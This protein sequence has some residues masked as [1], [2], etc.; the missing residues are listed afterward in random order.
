M[1][2][3]TTIKTL[4]HTYTAIAIIDHTTCALTM[5]DE[6]TVKQKMSRF[7]SPLI[8]ERS[9]KRS[10]KSLEPEEVME[11]MEVIDIIEDGDALLVVNGISAMGE[12][13]VGLRVS[14]FALGMVSNLESKIFSTKADPHRPRRSSRH[15]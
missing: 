10:R 13:Q 1:L 8:G 6:L 11:V 9:P 14:S 3:P 5:D 7:A 2:L 15:T 4:A 12:G